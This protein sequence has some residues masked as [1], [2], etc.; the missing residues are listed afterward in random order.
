M[1]GVIFNILTT[2]ALDLRKGTLFINRYKKI[3]AY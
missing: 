2:F 3:S 1:G